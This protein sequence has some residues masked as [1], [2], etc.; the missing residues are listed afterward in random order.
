MDDIQTKFL[1]AELISRYGNALDSG[2]FDELESL[3]TDDAVFRIEPDTGV[4]PLQGKRGI[5]MA[6]ERRWTLVHMESQ[7]RHVM[8]NIVVAP[9]SADG[10]SSTART[11]LVVYEVG[12]APGS[13]IHLHGMGVYEDALVLEAGQ[14]RFR[15]RRLILDRSDYFA[16]G[17][18][19]IR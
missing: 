8:S 16:P 17:W 10:C 3:F 13:Q 18:T 2:A 5:R 7:R 4:P 14:W 11:V 15:E 6:V 1:I 12:K 19:S 9:V